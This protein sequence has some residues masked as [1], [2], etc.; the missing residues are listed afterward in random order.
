M[1]KVNPKLVVLQS[2][3]KLQVLEKTF[4]QKKKKKKK[5]LPA[6]LYRQDMQ[7]SMQ[8]FFSNK[9]VLRD[10]NFFGSEKLFFNT[11]KFF[12]KTR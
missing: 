2:Q 3:T 6:Y 5:N 10:L 12:N 4:F 9:W 8:K 1:E 11:N 7:I